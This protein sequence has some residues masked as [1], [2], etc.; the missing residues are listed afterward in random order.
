MPQESLPCL[1]FD[2]R[3][4]GREFPLYSGRSAGVGA[5]AGV[6]RIFHPVTEGNMEQL[7]KILVAL[8]TQAVQVADGRA[9]RKAI[10]SALESHKTVLREQLKKVGKDAFSGWCK[11]HKVHR[12]VASMVRSMVWPVKL[13]TFKIDAR[14]GKALEG[15][16]P[17]DHAQA[18]AFVRALSSWVAKNRTEKDE[19]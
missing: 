10:A 4:S 15:V 12:V 16:V 2:C 7:I 13:A 5:G 9:A 17:A 11:E 6:N 1:A 14:L 8:S 18:V 19:E 3:D